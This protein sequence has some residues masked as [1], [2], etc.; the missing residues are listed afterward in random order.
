MSSAGIQVWDANG[1]LIL[2]TSMT[3]V[4]WLGQISVGSS[5]TGSAQSG[6]V[7][8]PEFATYPNNK[9]FIARMDGKLAP[10]SFGDEATFWVEG[11]YIKWAFP[12]TSRNNQTVAYGLL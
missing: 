8:V 3:V 6:Q 7:S 4:K 10:N 11:S 5:Y 1:V 2:D 9:P 12:G